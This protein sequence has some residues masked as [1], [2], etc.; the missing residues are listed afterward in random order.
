MTVA[1]I[2]SACGVLPDAAG[3]ALAVPRVRLL[4]DV[5]D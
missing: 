3:D 5:R 2:S 4:G 1:V